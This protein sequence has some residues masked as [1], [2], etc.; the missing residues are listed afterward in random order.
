MRLKDHVAR[1]YAESSRV[2]VAAP[3]MPCCEGLSGG[4]QSALQLNEC[5]S[6]DSSR[7]D[8]TRIW[9]HETASPKALDR[10]RPGAA[11]GPSASTASRSCPSHHR[12]FRQASSA[13]ADHPHPRSSKHP[14]AAPNGES[15]S[16]LDLPTKAF[17]RPPGLSRLSKR[18]CRR[19]ARRSAMANPCIYTRDGL[20][21]RRGIG[22]RGSL[23]IRCY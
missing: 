12:H 14:A 4:Q 9:F 15:M 13:S 8:D 23:R 21:L 1:H 22:W 17:R 6:A 20:H 7:I 19:S 3:D 16:F 11:A 10:L 2:L 18:A 5:V